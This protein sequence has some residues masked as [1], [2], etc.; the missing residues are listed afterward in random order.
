MQNQLLRLLPVALLL[1]VALPVGI[2]MLGA[3]FVLFWLAM[4]AYLGWWTLNALAD[5]EADEPVWLERRPRT[6]T[7][8]RVGP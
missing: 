6:H 5:R 2:S 1:L 4:T 3:K 8:P 7:H